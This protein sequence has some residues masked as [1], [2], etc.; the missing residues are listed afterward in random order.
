MRRVLAC[1]IVLLPSA[2]TDAQASKLQRLVPSITSFATDGVRYAAWQ[3]RES[4]PLTVLD[5]STGRRRRLPLRHGC[6]LVSEEHASVGFG[7]AAAD[8]R[9]LIECVSTEVVSVLNLRTDAMRALP[10][11]GGWF[12]LGTY[13]ARGQ[14]E[15]GRQVVVDVA[16]GRVTRVS[17]VEY[18]EL[19]RPGAPRVCPALRGRVK[20]LEVPVTGEFSYENDL[21]AKWG[22]SHGTVKLERCDG[23]ST[24]L[25]GGR[26]EA[27][28]ARFLDLR[29]GVVTWDTADSEGGDGEPL[30][31]G[32]RLDAY[33]LGTHRRQQWVLPALR[34]P[35]AGGSERAS[36]HAAGWSTHTR[37]TVF[38]LPDREM[39]CEKTCRVETLYLYAARL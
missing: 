39:E 6:R 38:W 32:N 28:R 17:G 18:R 2:A 22:G 8:G 23:S 34:I 31:R 20:R 27:G 26:G 12:T 7:H 14:N 30:E 10:R 21:F 1:L 33:T 9:V 37:N 24:V 35:F 13:Y 16:A 36:G 25:A 15:E 29:D 5:T 19:N 3:T 11:G 4:S